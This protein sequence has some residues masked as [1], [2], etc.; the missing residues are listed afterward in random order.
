[1]AQLRDHGEAAPSLSLSPPPLA[2]G[3]RARG[4]AASPSPSALPDRGRGKIFPLVTP[5]PSPAGIPDRHRVPGRRRWWRTGR[6][7]PVARFLQRVGHFLRHVGFVV[8][9]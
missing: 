5:P 4:Q 2:G 1:M 8:L 6:G 3:D 7:I 9:G